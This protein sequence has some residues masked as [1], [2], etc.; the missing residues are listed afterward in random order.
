MKNGIKNEFKGT[1]SVDDSDSPLKAASGELPM[2]E[3]SETAQDWRA[4]NKAQI[5]SV[6]K[7]AGITLVTAYYSGSCDDGQ[8]DR[9]RSRAGKRASTGNR[10]TRG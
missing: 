8:I 9:H 7:A 10:F 4:S 1:G 6:L 5:L 3:A 2:I